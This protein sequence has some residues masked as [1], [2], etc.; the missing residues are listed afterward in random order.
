MVGGWAGLTALVEGTRDRR[1][2]A[3]PSGPHALTPHVPEPLRWLVRGCSKEPT[4]AEAAA[5][6]VQDVLY[7]PWQQAMSSGTGIAGLPP[8]PQLPPLPPPLRL[9]NDQQWSNDDALSLGGSYD[10][11]DDFFAD[12][13]EVSCGGPRA[14]K[15]AA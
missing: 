15:Q 13:F 6:P 5:E 8:R 3:L 1:Q 10:P 2:R 7:P 4:A 14:H 9:H 11:L 12:D